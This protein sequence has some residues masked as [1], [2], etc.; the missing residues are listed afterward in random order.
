MARQLSTEAARACLTNYGGFAF[1]RKYDIEHKAREAWLS[2]SAFI[3][4]NL[5]S[6]FI[7]QHVPGVPESG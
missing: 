3:S 4:P 1:A 2:R 5:M 6:S 7:G